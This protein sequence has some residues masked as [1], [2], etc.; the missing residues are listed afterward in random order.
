MVD[1]KDNFLDVQKEKIGPGNFEITIFKA[2]IRNK[3][4]RRIL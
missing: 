4:K 2:T 3:N 1:S